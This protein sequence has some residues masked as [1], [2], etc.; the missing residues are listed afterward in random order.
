[1]QKNIDFSS[2]NITKILKITEKS[3]KFQIKLI[4]NKINSTEEMRNVIFV[5]NSLCDGW[6]NDQNLGISK[7]ENY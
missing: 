3:I 5:S 2:Q 6:K 7:I 4:R 1:M